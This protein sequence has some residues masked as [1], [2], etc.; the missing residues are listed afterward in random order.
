[1]ETLLRVLLCLVEIGSFGGDYDVLRTGV[2]RKSFVSM[3][4]FDQNSVKGIVF[5][6]VEPKWGR[7]G[8]FFVGKGNERRIRQP[9]FYS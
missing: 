4:F 6:R 1:M 7:G 2:A 8:V 5:N 3:P 9:F